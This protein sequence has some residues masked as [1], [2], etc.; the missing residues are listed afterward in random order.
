MPNPRRD[1]PVERWVQLYAEGLS[2]D[3]IALFHEAETG[4]HVSQCTVGKRL[5]EAG[6]PQREQGRVPKGTRTF[7]CAEVRRLRA[8]G[9]T[10]A[11][12]GERLGV[13]HMSAWR[14]ARA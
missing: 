12:I 8:E 1:Y 7:D 11:A 3:R 5:R 13:S 10:Y 14:G 6:V 2:Q 4:Q 9:L